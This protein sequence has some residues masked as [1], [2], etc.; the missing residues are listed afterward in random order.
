MRQRRLAARTDPRVLVASAAVMTGPNRSKAKVDTADWQ[1]QA[2]AFYDTVGELRFGASWIAN[3]LSRVNLVAAVPPAALG[4]EPVAVDL[5][6]SPGLAAYV[7]LVEG[8]AGGSAG[9]GQLLGAT[10]RLLTV[11]GVG[12]VLATVDPVSDTFTT[13][14]A[15]SNEE[16]QA[17][18]GGGGG[19]E[20]ADPDTGTFAPL[21]ETDLLIK[22]WRSHPRKAHLPDS[23]VRALLD[24]LGEIDLLTKRIAA[25]AR[26]RLAGN[27]LLIMPEEAEFPPGQGYNT[28]SSEGV[29]EFIETFV[30]VTTIPITDQSSPAATTPLVVRMPG[31]FVDKVQHL[32]F[33]SDF[34]AQLVTIRQAAIRRLA[35]GLDMPPEVLLG[36]GAS[37]HWSAWQVAEEAITLHV[38]PLAELICHAFTIGYLR[39]AAK[40]AG[41]DPDAVIVWYD[42]SDLTTRPDLTAAATDAHEKRLIADETYLQLVGLDGADLLDWRG[43]EFKRRTLLD[44]A[45]GAPTLAP[46]ML[47][48][49]GILPDEVA[50]AAADAETGAPA[51][52]GEA[53][54]AAEPATGERVPPAQDEALTAACDGLVVRALERAGARLVNA[55]RR[56]GV[57]VSEVDAPAVAHTMLSA[58]EVAS[59]DHLLADAWDRTSLIGLRY[60]VSAESLTACLDSYTRALIATGRPH[61]YDRL[62]AALGVAGGR[63][64]AA[65]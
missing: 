56:A 50:V 55:A 1:K 62:A 6:V 64:L 53:D 26:S 58:T 13:W 27:G 8:I 40:A 3:A 17:S 30:Q 29:D 36:M 46:A 14:R 9:Q 43:E 23:P 21:A 35:L 59:L 57:D 60:R 51:P 18:A 25:D 61:E 32:K 24:V 2:W 39:P 54:V 5:E 31:E 45:K 65:D 28:P 33:Y 44:V 63:R 34:S 19:I 20:V 49:A 37:N 16:V 52:S 48:A 10:A 41:L 7:A 47:A 12:Y 22:V 4:D 42:T 38:E 15:L 11:P